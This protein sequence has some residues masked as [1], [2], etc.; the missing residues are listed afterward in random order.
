MGKKLYPIC[1]VLL[2]VFILSGCSQRQEEA[3]G[4]MLIMAYDKLYAYEGD[5]SDAV[6]MGD[7]G[8]VGGIIVSTVWE[9][10]VPTSNGQT[11]FGELGSH[12]TKGDDEMIEVF[13]S[14]KDG[15]YNFY[16][17]EQ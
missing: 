11:N 5:F 4:R 3:N 1:A 10:E 13:I 12:Y 7:S 6:P 15:W 17:V 9:N 14:E 16:R 8:C 2:I